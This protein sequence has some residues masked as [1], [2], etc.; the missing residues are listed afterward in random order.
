MTNTIEALLPVVAD[1]WEQLRGCDVFRLLEEISNVAGAQLLVAAS[2]VMEQR[3]DLSREVLDSIDELI[4][5]H[6][7]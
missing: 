5:E 4:G 2:Y 7:G 6:C 3:P 1:S